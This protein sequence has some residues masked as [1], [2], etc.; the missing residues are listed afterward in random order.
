VVIE[1]VEL[2]TAALGSALLWHHN[3]RLR[4]RH[5]ATS[6][7]LLCYVPLFCVYPVVGRVLSEGAISIDTRINS[8]LTDPSIYYVYQSYIILILLGCLLVTVN[9]PRLSKI[10]L[11][12]S[13]GVDRVLISTTWLFFAMAFGI[14]LY[15]YSTGLSIV[16]LF[17]ASRFE[18][19]LS[20]NYSS[21][22]SVV[23]SYFVA[24]APAVIY[25]CIREDRRMMLVITLVI[26]IG[27]GALSKD[28]KWLI[29]IASGLLAARYIKANLQISLSTREMT[30]F[31]SFGVIMAFWQVVRGTLFNSFVTGSAD[32][33]TEVPFMIEQLLTRGDLP[34][35]YNASATAIHMNLNDGFSIPLGLLRRQLF[36][37]LPANFSFGLKIEDISAIFSDAIEAG[38]EVRRGNMP[39][40][41][42]GLLVLSF[43]WWGGLIFAFLLPFGLRALD[44]FIRRQSGILQIALISNLL[45]ALLLLLRGDDSSATYF[46][47]FTIIVMLSLK[48][49]RMLGLSSGVS[50]T[51]PQHPRKY[52]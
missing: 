41:L 33:S 26:L 1:A 22:L 12:S 40:G 13:T 7:F 21:L 31:A 34:Y 50:Q 35:Y 29:F 16:E 4:F 51:H 42:I 24:L 44:T 18:W 9:S 43:E 37:F 17:I 3:I 11:A 39:P 5:F 47:V 14:Y 46:I 30:L 27:Y 48:V 28:R 36:L 2:A 15:V 8:T 49:G 32:L 20:E 45:S 6:V 25:L 10:R 19:F 52:G 38:D 23:A